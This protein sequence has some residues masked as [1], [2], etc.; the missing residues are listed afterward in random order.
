MAIVIIFIEPP[1][2]L[3]RCSHTDQKWWEGIWRSDG[4]PFSPVAM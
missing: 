4:T 3:H 1:D 2:N